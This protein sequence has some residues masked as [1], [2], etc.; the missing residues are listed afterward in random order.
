MT[1]TATTAHKG[2]W[3]VYPLGVV[4]PERIR[5]TSTMR[6]TWGW[7]VVCSCGWDSMTG[8]ATKRSVR[9]EFENHK[10]DADFD[11]QLAKMSAK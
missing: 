3:Y 1:T 4:N 10:W 9:R 8:G 6:G 11:A 2:T 5:H 7:D